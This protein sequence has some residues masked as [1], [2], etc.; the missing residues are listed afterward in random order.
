MCGK[1]L[2]NGRNLKKHM[3]KI[4]GQ[5]SD[6]ATSSLSGDTLPAACDPLDSPPSDKYSGEFSKSL[7]Y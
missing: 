4:H 7:L 2:A 5:A 3:D 6:K 1:V